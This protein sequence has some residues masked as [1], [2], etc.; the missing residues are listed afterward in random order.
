[1]NAIAS[2]CSQRLVVVVSAFDPCRGYT[3]GDL[4]DTLQR[5]LRLFGDSGDFIEEVPDHFVTTGGDSERKPG[6]DDFNDREDTSQLNP[7]EDKADRKYLDEV[8][9]DL[10]DKKL[11][12]LL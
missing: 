1:M 4:L 10:A 8:E 5:D 6:W 9:A 2:K 3:V 11:K 12:D 7:N